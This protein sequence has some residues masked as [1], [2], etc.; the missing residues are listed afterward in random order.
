MTHGEPRS[1]WRFGRPQRSGVAL[2]KSPTLSDDWYTVPMTTTIPSAGTAFDLHTRFVEYRASHPAMDR[3]LHLGYFR[4]FTGAPVTETVS[5]ATME[6]ELERS[7]VYHDVARTVD[8]AILTRADTVF[9]TDDLRELVNTAETT[10]PDEVLF[11]TDVYTPCGFVLME[12]P[13]LLD[14]PSRMKA[15]EFDEIVALVHKHGGN[16]QGTRAHG[17]PDEFGDLIGL[18]HWHIHGYAWADVRSITPEALADVARRFGS[19]SVEHE[20]ARSVF[21]ARNGE[22]GLYVRVYGTM[23]ATTVDGVTIDTPALNNAPLRLV[24][25]YAFFYGENGLD[26]ENSAYGPNTH[27]DE[28]TKASWSRSRGIR[29]FIVALFRLMEEYVELD[30]SATPRAH[31]RRATRGGRIG[32]VKN[33]TVLSLRRA[34]YDET[35]GATGRKVTLAHLVRGHWRNQWYPSQQQHRAKWIRAHRRGGNAGDEVTERPRVIVVDR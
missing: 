17:A 30:K 32:D 8:D 29:R 9:L 1:P 14:I 19:G 3:L 28:M 11:E 20:F 6:R 25:Q 18:E 24:E 10:M 35:D 34:L 33:V 2:D 23:T 22:K 15:N 12:T 16:A 13:L 27:D 5:R 4:A 26:E 31:G 7:R 21:L